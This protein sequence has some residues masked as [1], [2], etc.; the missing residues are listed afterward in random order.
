MIGL[1]S[2]LALAFCAGLLVKTVDWID[3]ERKGKN[4]LKWPLALVYGVL[5]GSLISQSPVSMLFLGALFAQVFAGKIDTHTHVFGFAVAMLMPL[6]LGFPSFDPLLF[7][8]FALLA[9]ID[10]MEYPPRLGWI[11]EWRPALPIG[12]A[13]LIVSGRFD[14]FLAIASFDIGYALFVFAQTRVFKIKQA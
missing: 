11:N 5:I 12:A 9:F 3:D 10:E 1:V 13:L 2:A 14:Y 7:G 6:V 8:F 4:P